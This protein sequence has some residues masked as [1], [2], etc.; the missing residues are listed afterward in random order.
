[1]I[2]TGIDLIQLFSDINSNQIILKTNYIFTRASTDFL[3]ENI[4]LYNYT[5]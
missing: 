4:I 5:F 2:H 1:L 3:T